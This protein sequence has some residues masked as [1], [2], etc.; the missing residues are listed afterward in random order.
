MKTK[1]MRSLYITE[2][3]NLD[4]LLHN[5]LEAGFVEFDNATFKTFQALN[6]YDNEGVNI[7]E[8]QMKYDNIRESRRYQEKE[9]KDL[10]SQRGKTN[11]N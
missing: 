10:K 4:S 11:D 1:I 5:M 3:K 6:F 8:Y 2:K 7:I 9:M